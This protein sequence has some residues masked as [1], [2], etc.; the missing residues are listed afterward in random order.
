MRWFEIGVDQIN[1]GLLRIDADDLM[2]FPGE[3]TRR[4]GP[5][6]PETP[7]AK[8]HDRLFYVLLESTAE[9][10]LQEANFSTGHCTPPGLRGLWSQHRKGLLTPVRHPPGRM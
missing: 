3:A 6:V 2:T 4:N 5:D 9:P 7:D 8:L 1:L 10:A